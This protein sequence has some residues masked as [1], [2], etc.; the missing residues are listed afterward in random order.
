[1]LCL[2]PVKRTVST[3]ISA[4]N[5]TEASNEVFTPFTTVKSKDKWV[6]V[7]FWFF[8]GW[9]FAAHRWYYARPVLANIL[10]IITFGGFGIWAIIDLINMLTDK[11]D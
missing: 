10:F 9:P 2:F 6:G 1:M 7:A 11:W 4:D 3:T 8:L 5:L